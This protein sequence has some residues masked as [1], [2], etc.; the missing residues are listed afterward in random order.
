VT[1]EQIMS[2]T[3]LSLERP[4]VVC[5]VDASSTSATLLNVA[6]AYC[7]KRDAELLLVWVIEPS[8]FGP[9]H[10]R[11]S[12]GPAI[13]GLSGAVALALE[14]ARREGVEARTVVRIGD[15]GIVLEE[16]RRAVGA[17]RVFTRADPHGGRAVSPRRARDERVE[18]EAA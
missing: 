3:R 11:S 13:W 17:V 16:E 18:S 10:P 8:S 12:S 14:R 1:K 5:H 2:T 15:P 9:A 6:G 4:C 7:R